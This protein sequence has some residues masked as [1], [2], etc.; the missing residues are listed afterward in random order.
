MVA[1]YYTAGWSHQ[2]I[3]AHMGRT[4]AGVKTTLARIRKK[5]RPRAPGS[6]LPSA[7]VSISGLDSPKS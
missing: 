2:E 3:A 7:S 4:P 1:L 6:R 5:L